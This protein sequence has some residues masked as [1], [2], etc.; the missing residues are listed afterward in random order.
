MSTTWLTLSEAARH[1]QSAY[2]REGRSISRKTVSRWAIS[3]LVAAE[4]NGSRWRVDR[5]SL[6]AHIAAQ[7]SKMSAEEEAKGPHLI[8]QARLDRLSRAVA[9][10]NAD[11]MRN[12]AAGVD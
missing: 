12:L 9:R 10:R 2:A 4:R 1:V 7:L 6:A 11:F 8:E 5:D 3:G